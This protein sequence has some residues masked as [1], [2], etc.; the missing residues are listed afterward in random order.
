MDPKEIERIGTFTRE[1]VQQF[2]KAVPDAAGLGVAGR[3]YLE[4]VGTALVFFY[5]DGITIFY[6]PESEARRNN[7]PNGVIAYSEE[8]RTLSEVLQSKTRNLVKI[9]SVISEEPLRRDL[10]N[11]EEVFPLPGDL[12]DAEVQTLGASWELIQ[13]AKRFKELKLLGIGIGPT[14]E[15]KGG[16]LVETL[17]TRWR[18]YSPLIRLGDGTQV[19]QFMWSFIDI[20]WRPEELGLETELANLQAKVDVE[21]LLLGIE[22][23]IPNEVLC[24]DP[25]G[26]VGQHCLDICDEFELLINGPDIGEDEVQHFLEGKKRWFLIVPAHKE[27]FPKRRLGGGKFVPDFV[28]HRPDDDYHLVEIESPWMPIY[29]RANEEQAAHLT[30][31]LSQVEDWLRY[32]EENRDSVRREDGMKGMNQP[33]GEVIAGRD[34][35]LGPMAKRRFDFANSSRKIKVRTY[36]MLLKDSREY[37]RVIL[38]MGK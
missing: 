29:Q 11:F 4:P 17:P 34:S 21:V 32:I 28:I 26:T 22:A 13:A 30:H 33:T 8:E 6:L 23:G 31:A 18:C 35:Q 37:A 14:R 3:I 2:N 27:V 19:R 24:Q 5:S 20:L 12:V 16:Q 38:E 36:D 25:F 10:S 15:F 7:F 1:Y 9:S